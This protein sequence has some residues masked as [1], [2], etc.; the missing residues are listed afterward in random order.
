MYVLGG[1]IRIMYNTD[2]NSLSL[3][4]LNC[5][6]I[7]HNNATQQSQEVL[8]YVPIINSNSGELVYLYMWEKKI[9]EQSGI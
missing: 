6:H 2:N 9:M 8:Q 1:C 5:A 3:Y 7:M 4:N